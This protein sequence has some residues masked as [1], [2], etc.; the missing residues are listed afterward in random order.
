MAIF[1][2]GNEIN[3]NN[4]LILN[5]VLQTVNYQEHVNKLLAQSGPVDEITLPT[6]LD[7]LDFGNKVTYAS[8]SRSGNTFFRRYL[9]QIGGIFTGSDG[10]LNYALH[11]SLQF[12]GFSGECKV[13]NDCWFI[14]THYPLGIEVPFIANKVIIC[15][16]NPLD[17]VTSVF[18]FWSSQTQNLSIEQQ[19]FHTQF[20][21]DWQNL[22]KQEISCWR[23]WHN[24]WI[25]KAREENVPA[26]FFRFED[27]T[28]NPK[29]ILMNVFAFTLNQSSVSG[30]LIESKID[31]LIRKKA[32]G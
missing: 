26:Y 14:K 32:E 21:Q 6:F 23:D 12:C 2:R 31:L 1:H 17:V 29:D 13:D 10:D 16:R 30:T 25:K 28:K 11:Y 22:V 15:V 4:G 7:G 19:D 5:E 27:I 18:N 9:E 3:R 24:F 8:Y 20:P